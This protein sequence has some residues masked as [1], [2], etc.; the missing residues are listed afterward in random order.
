MNIVRVPPTFG[1]KIQSQNEFFARNFSDLFER[2]TSALCEVWKLA[3]HVQE[4]VSCLSVFGKIC[5]HL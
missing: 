4:K 1:T 3:P 5:L 2:S